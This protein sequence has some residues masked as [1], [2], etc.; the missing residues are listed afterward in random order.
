MPID[1]QTG[2]LLGTATPASPPLWGSPPPTPSRVGRGLAGGQW[3]LVSFFPGRVCHPAVW[4]L[5]APG[6]PLS[7][8]CWVGLARTAV[9]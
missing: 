7:V 9:G 6:L 1:I 5:T 3:S 4:Q 8:S 2:K